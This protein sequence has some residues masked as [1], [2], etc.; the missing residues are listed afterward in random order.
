M[1]CWPM[2]K[3]DRQ[4]DSGNLPSQR[5]CAQKIS[6]VNPRPSSQ[7]A[8]GYSVAALKDVVN[9]PD[10]KRQQYRGE[11]GGFVYKF[12]KVVDGDTL[13]VV[14]ELKKDECWLISAFW[15]T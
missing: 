13:A 4:R 2:K 8:A 6:R 15:P 5:A 3:V 12:T 11:H 14:A 7:W 1:N 9:Y 10:A